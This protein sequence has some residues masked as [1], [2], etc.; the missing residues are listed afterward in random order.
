[1]RR[2]L[3]LI[4]SIV[5]A[6]AIFAVP[7]NRRPFVVKQSDGTTLSLVHTGDEAL[8][9]FMT[10][11]GFPVVKDA[12]GDYM[13][14]TFSQDGTFLSTGVVAH[15][16][17]ARNSDE[18]AL[19]STIDC[20]A[21]KEKV[22]N[23]HAA[24]SAKYRKA[25][26]ARSS[27]I[28]TQGEV[29]I[30]VLLVQF[31]D[32]KF[33]FTK[34]DINKLLN[35][36]NYKYNFADMYTAY[37][38]ARD[39]F[40]AQSGGL[41]KPE[42]VVTDIVT[43]PQPM[44]YYGGNDSSG[45]D[46]NPQA[47]IRDGIGL[48][49]ATMNFAQFD[50]NLDG[51]IEFLYCIYAGYS[52]STGADSN[53]VWPHQWVLSSNGGKK[54]ADGVYCDTYACSSELSLNET[55]EQNSRKYLA[56]IGTICH[57]FSHCLG[58]HDVYDVSGS[59]GNWGMDEWDLMDLGSYAAEG[60]IP[61]GYNSYQKEA[62]GWQKLQE[63]DKKG[64][65]SM[66][67]QTQNGVGYKIVN[68]ANPNEYYI[69]ENRK[70]EGWDQTLQADGMMII[71]VDYDATVWDNNSI[72]TT[73]GHPRF[74]LVPADNDL[75][76][77]GTVSTT[78]FYESMA[79]DLWPGAA[80]NTE[81]T[82]TSVPAA[83]VFTGGYLNK[84]VTKIKY[85]NYVASFAFMG[86]EIAPPE[87]EPATDVTEN[88]FVA[89]WTLVDDATE[90]FLELYRQ[91]ESADGDVKKLLE[92]DFAQC[93]Y[94]GSSITD[95]LDAYMTTPGWTGYNLYSERGVMRIGAYSSYGYAETP[96]MNASGEIVVTF[97]VQKYNSNDV[98]IDLTVDVL[99]NSENV[100]MTKNITAEGAVEL[101]CNVDGEF[102][103]R[104]S[105]SKNA[106]VKRALMDNLVVSVKSL[107]KNELKEIVTTE[108]DNYKFEGLEEG[109][110]AYR[111]KAVDGDTESEFS[112]YAEVVL[113]AT[114]IVEISGAEN[115]YIEVYTL[116][117]VMIYNGKKEYMPNLSHGIYIIRNG[118]YVEKLFY[119]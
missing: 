1:M 52:E 81:F 30:P 110:Y 55:S 106:T 47:M 85:E 93:R 60:Y 17:E 62:C 35:E 114:G 74:Q 95:E 4:I 53:T 9:Y 36:E 76:V 73:S 72:N 50:N 7:A 3:S 54:Y 19:L 38:S 10:T 41:F 67:P 78:E 31:S 65:Y 109:R 16:V 101:R 116:N 82:N 111:V 69:L 98:G 94:S 14:A 80:R 25:A 115:G 34:E 68:D 18:V 117:G 89:N 22:T 15:N 91:V 43:L 64:I 27:S 24:R 99:Y 112:E 96:L 104:F 90:Y 119:K 21:V 86:G 8:H 56:G 29:F 71:H 84:P 28:I 83:K 39:Y 88:S 57:E 48:A 77:Y 108:S 51:E 70:R 11:D 32:V 97:D 37:G 13:Y 66:L 45:D 58:L 59:S 103:I 2:F 20:D 12:S 92:E 6:V 46:K 44:A 107:Y 61:V 5:I 40:I 118:N 79:K 49:D 23:V 63:L 100:I 42:F 113:S 105:T 102:Y 87:I 26:T 33:T 75:A